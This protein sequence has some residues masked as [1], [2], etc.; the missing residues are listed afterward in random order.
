MV[1]D[2]LLRLSE[3]SVVAAG[4]ALLTD[5]NLDIH[6]GESVVVLGGNGSGKT[7]LLKLCNGLLA[8]TR[9]TVLAPSVAAQALIFQRPPYL[10]RSVIDNVRF[11]LA[12]RGVV[13]PARTEQ[14]R[15][16]L[17]ACDLG[18]IE[19][20]HGPLLSGGELQ[21]LA[22]ARAWAC[23]PT[24]LLADEPTSNLAPSATREVERL[25]QSVRAQGTTLLL[26]THNVAQAKRLAQRILFLEGG[27]IVED[28]HAV[29]FFASPQSAAA[30][31]YLDGESL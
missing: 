24:L 7:T 19:A 25:I 11:V 13:E 15:A 14:A 17:I 29:D 10:A 22:L 27:R 6:A 5:I 30:R 20:R 3:V 4:K 23:Q 21:R 9:G 1:N 8:P 12:M 16:A 18:E 28:R 2:V 26:T 31:N